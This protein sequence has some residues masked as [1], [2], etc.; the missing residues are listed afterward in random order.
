META[1][2]TSLNNQKNVPLQKRNGQLK[3]SQE[4]MFG[5]DIEK[6]I[7]QLLSIIEQNESIIE[8]K[9]IQ[10]EKLKN[11][12]YLLRKK[13][14]GRTS[15]RYVKE[16]PN[17][18]KIDFGGEDMLPE[19]VQVQ[20]EVSK[21]TVTYERKK[22]KENT[23]HPVRQPLPS[24]LERR[25]E[26]IEPKPLPEGS[27][28]IGE[29]VTEI[30]EYT[31]GSF[32]VRR[33]VRRKY[34]LHKESGVVI[35]ELPSL[36]LPKSNAGSSLLAHLLVNKYQDHLPF[37]RQI[38]MFGRQGLTLASATVNGWFSSSVD[39]L[40]PLYDC[41]KEEV[42]SSDYIQI[43][44]TTIPVMD[45]D[46]P[47]ATKKGYHWI[48]RAPEERKLYFHY[49]EGSRA[50]RVAVE[51]L[52]DFKGAV[53]SDGYGAYN[54]YENKKNVLLL[55]CWAHARRKFSEALKNDPQRASFALGQIQQL[56][57]L[58]RQAEDE[59][60]TKEQIEELRKTKSYPL[61][62]AFEK[63]LNT[64]YSQVLP[65]SSIGQAIVYTYNIYPRLVRYVIDGRYKIDNNG[66]EN[67]V[68]PLALGR[69]NYLFCGNHEAA[70]R[71]AIIYSLLGTC[72]INNV[73]PTLWLTDVFNTIP[74]CKINDLNKLLPDKW[75]KMDEGV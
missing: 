72:K 5:T 10:I 39:L 7:D 16:D 23:N 73:N 25:E 49:D 43:D 12:I 54:I 4:I 55:G 66:V 21:E 26:I 17:Q 58:E 71:T 15:E 70:K 52:K 34:A 30:L 74:D 18:L 63:W 68:R 27:K 42:L 36:A 57:R 59:N 67:G 56:Y 13:L 33:I 62:K 41:L 40:T 47:G 69:K 9:D 31:P 24:H 61:M 14:F 44:E 32:Y 50:Q 28:C 60:M 2:V 22:K 46:H 38:E 11:E 6:E 64:N 29:E 48:I 37:Y 51:I 19:E 3:S 1:L 65:K 35:G 20:L 53:Q 75:K 45:K 8:Q